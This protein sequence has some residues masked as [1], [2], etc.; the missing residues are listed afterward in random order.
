MHPFHDLHYELYE[1]IVQ[2]EMQMKA[3]ALTVISST[4]YYS[5]YSKNPWPKT[6]KDIQKALTPDFAGNKAMQ[7]LTNIFL[8]EVH[9]PVY[10]SMK[11]ELINTISNTLF[12]DAN[13]KGLIEDNRIRSILINLQRSRGDPCTFDVDRP[14]EC[15]QILTSRL[16]DIAYRRAGLIESHVDTWS[17]REQFSYVVY[18]LQGVHLWGK[19]HFKLGLHP[20]PDKLTL[21]SY[22]GSLHNDTARKYNGIDLDKVMEMH[23]HIECWDVRDITDMS[24]MARNLVRFNS[25]IGAW[26]MSNVKNMTAMFDCCAQFNMPIGAWNVQNVNN[27]TAMFFYAVSFNQ[28]VGDWNVGNVELMGYMFSRARSFNQSLKNWNPLKLEESFNMLRE[29]TSFQYDESVPWYWKA[30][31]EFYK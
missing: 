8:H 25:P 20:I 26:D 18:V 11:N 15:R 30:I 1:Y 21:S 7:S 17:L 3:F 24:E 16:M 13:I 28:P 31:D 4:T 10:L 23:G 2:H 27:M 22:L 14:E 9:S 6:I 5:E 29:A 19:E 12:K